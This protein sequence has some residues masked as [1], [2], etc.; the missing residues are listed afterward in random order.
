MASVE[1]EIPPLVDG[2]KLSRTEFLRRWEAMPNVKRAELIGGVVHMPSPLSW[3]H[4]DIEQL[5][6][7]WL[8]NYRAST[9]GCTG[10]NSAT[11]LMED[12]DTPQPDISL[13]LLPEKGGQ[14]RREGKFITGTP[15]FLAEVSLSS[16]P[17]DLTTKR[18]LYRAN[19]VKEHMVALVNER[20]VRWFRLVEDE[21]EPL[22]PAADGIYRSEVFP[23]LWLDVK[24]L[25]ESDF[26]G[27][28]AVLNRGLQSPEHAAFVTK[29]SRLA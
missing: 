13:C 6:G 2:D 26:A 27:V 25:F 12:E 24:A 10:A 3:E 21:F 17:Y 1:L 9:P 8:G 5:V 11:W 4:G 14:S 7:T 15:E 28:L 19:R 23:G 18:E 29:L 20:E 16:G 22:P